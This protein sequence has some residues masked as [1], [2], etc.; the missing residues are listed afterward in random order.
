MR[1]AGREADAL[2]A[3]LAFGDEVTV[4]HKVLNEEDA[5]R[6]AERY[7][8]VIQDNY[9]YWLQ[10]YPVKQKSGAETLRCFQEFFGPQQKPKHMYSDNSGEI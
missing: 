9:T 10:A 7:A 4:D 1:S 5:G 8:V 6:D 2:P 3:P